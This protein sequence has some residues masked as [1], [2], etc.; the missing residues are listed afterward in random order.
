MIFQ[1]EDFTPYHEHMTELTSEDVLTGLLA[2][3]LFSEKIPPVFSTKKFYD[4]YRNPKTK[5]DGFESTPKDYIRYEN[6]RNINIPRPISIPHPFPYLKLCESIADNWK[7]LQDHFKNCT[8][9]QT[10]KIS[11]IHIRKLKNKQHTFEMNYL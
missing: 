7:K 1:T 2:H 5:K 6:I 9:N 11:R 3:G 10:H 8:K 4:F